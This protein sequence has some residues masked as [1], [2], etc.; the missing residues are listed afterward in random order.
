MK[1]LLRQIFPERFFQ[2]EVYWSALGLAMVVTLLLIAQL[3]T[4][5]DFPGVVETFGMPGGGVTVAVLVALIPLVEAASLPY[6]LSME[7]DRRTIRVSRYAAL[8]VGIM[9]A[10]ISIWILLMGQ[11]AAQSG[12]FGATIP[13]MGGVWAAAYSALLILAATLIMR[14]KRFAPNRT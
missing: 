10:L 3:Y 6:L 14:D 13:L 1:R 7:T 11:S 4:F 5:E 12:I 2:H 9:W 8:G